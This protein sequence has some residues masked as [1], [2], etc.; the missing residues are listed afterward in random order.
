M[1][2]YCWFK[3]ELHVV[4]FHRLVT[5][6]ARQNPDRVPLVTV[7]RCPEKPVVLVQDETQ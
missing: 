6:F 7:A 4:R 2:S 5:Y 1:L 3:V